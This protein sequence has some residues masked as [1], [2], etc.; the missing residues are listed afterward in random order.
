LSP[1]IPVESILLGGLPVADAAKTA[2]GSYASQI[3][4]MQEARILGQTMP[5][6][7]GLAAL[8]VSLKTLSNVVDK[9]PGGSGISLPGLDIFSSTM[10]SKYSKYVDGA[11]LSGITDTTKWYTNQINNSIVAEDARIPDI[12]TLTGKIPLNSIVMESVYEKYVNGQLTTQELGPIEIIPQTTLQAL[13]PN[14]V[15]T[16]DGFR[17]KLPPG[18]KPPGSY[19]L[20]STETEYYYINIAFPLGI[21]YFQIASGYSGPNKH[22][23]E[24]HLDGIYSPQVVTGAKTN[25]ILTTATQ[26][27]HDVGVANYIEILSSVGLQLNVIKSLIEGLELPSEIIKSV[28][29]GRSL[30]SMELLNKITNVRIFPPI[31]NLTTIPVDY[32]YAKYGYFDT[33]LSQQKQKWQF[34]FTQNFPVTQDE[35][36][37]DISTLNKNADIEAPTINS[38]WQDPTTGEY[39]IV[40]DMSYKFDDSF[41]TEAELTELLST[42]LLAAPD[43]P[44][45]FVELKSIS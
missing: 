15:I 4:A 10:L 22:I 35:M 41:A 7:A 12:I 27:T 18:R 33:A 32:F 6:L 3:V 21:S 39:F 25:N 1:V 23:V 28:Y 5:L 36:D 8:A 44:R 24:G 9:I 16:S 40:Y 29:T 42:I 14:A 38:F 37:A 2:V 31:Q 13:Y 45:V 19:T 30:A 43:N 26:T 34:T 20:G 17:Y 11:D